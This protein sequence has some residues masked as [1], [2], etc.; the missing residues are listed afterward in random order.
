MKGCEKQTSEAQGAEF[1]HAEKRFGV[2]VRAP[3]VL[4]IVVAAVQQSQHDGCC[5]MVTLVGVGWMRMC[6]S[7]AQTCL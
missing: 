5:V 3:T 6:S 2:V 7:S 4:S 1:L